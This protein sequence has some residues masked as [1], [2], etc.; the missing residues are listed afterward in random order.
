MAIWIRGGEVIDPVRS[1]SEKQDIIVDRGKIKGILPP[2]EFR[3][4]GPRLKIID[5]SGKILI[6]G[7]I[8]MHV[9]LREPGYE[10]KET[11]ATG[12]K[13]G[14]AGGFTGLACMPPIP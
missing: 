4:A 11:I 8:D 3:E 10:Y 1:V 5:A 7:L 2:G 6:P 12:A 9:H 13:A 14:V